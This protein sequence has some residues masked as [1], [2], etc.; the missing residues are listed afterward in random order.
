[1]RHRKIK[2][3]VG[4]FLIVSAIGYLITTSISRGRH[5]LLHLRGHLQ[6]QDPLLPVLLQFLE[7]DA[8]ERAG[9]RLL[10]GAGSEIPT[11]I[12]S[13]PTS[14][15]RRRRVFLPGEPNVQPI[16]S[17]PAVHIVGVGRPGPSLA[18]FLGASQPTTRD[19]S[20]SL[21]ISAG[22][23]S[24]LAA[25]TSPGASTES[26]NVAILSLFRCQAP[27][28]SSWRCRRAS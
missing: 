20:A 8:A 25:R 2:F 4:A 3:A 19:S 13:A 16:F 1:M 26:T 28:Q 7:V 12:S 6:G 9:G 21:C 5:G 18:C 23:T 22:M 24:A 14:V 17:R 15:D 11:A 10:S 27:R